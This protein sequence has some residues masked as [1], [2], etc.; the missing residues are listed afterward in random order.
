MS[1]KNTLLIAASLIAIAIAA[2]AYWFLNSP[3]YAFQCAAQA[4]RKHDVREF[5]KYV[6]VHTVANAAVE[7]LLAQP[8]RQSGMGLLE[9]IVGLAIVSV[10]QPSAV[11]A[12]EAQIDKW[13]L[14]VSPRASGESSSEPAAATNSED[15]DEPQADAQP[16]S[17]FGRIAALV[18]PPSLRQ[19]FRDYGFTKKNYRGFNQDDCQDNIAHVTLKFDSPKLHREVPVRLELRRQHDRWQITRVANLQELV[20]MLPAPQGRE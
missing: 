9:R 19:V 6:D 8:I 15:D 20:S 17:I 3:L 14:H 4:V 10:F 2:A 1:R 18:K 5:H 7:D 16:Q 12:M 13:V 11:D